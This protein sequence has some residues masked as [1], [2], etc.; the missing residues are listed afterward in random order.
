MFLGI[1]GMVRKRDL[2]AGCQNSHFKAKMAFDLA[3]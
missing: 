2:A 3:A 1:A